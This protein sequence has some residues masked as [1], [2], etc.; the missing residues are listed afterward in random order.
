MVETCVIKW[1]CSLVIM[2]YNSSYDKYISQLL[3]IYIYAHK[4]EGRLPIK[5]THTHINKTEMHIYTYA[6]IISNGQDALCLPICCGWSPVSPDAH[7]QPF[8]QPAHTHTGENVKIHRHTH[9]Q[10]NRELL[11]AREE[12]KND[13]GKGDNIN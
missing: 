12:I 11:H 2:E 6:Y 13:I 1:K 5:H 7:S 9:V 4:E 10:K 8:T 3:Y